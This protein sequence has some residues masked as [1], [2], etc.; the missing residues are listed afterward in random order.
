MWNQD[1]AVHPFQLV[2]C[3]CVCWT[4]PGR[5]TATTN[6][7]KPDGACGVRAKTPEFCLP[8]HI[9]LL[10][11]GSVW[12]IAW[13]M[14]KV[15]TTNVRE[16]RCCRFLCRCKKKCTPL[17]VFWVV[18]LR[19]ARGGQLGVLP[20]CCGDAHLVRVSCRGIVCDN[21]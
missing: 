16:S 15:F 18:I 14:Y 7:Q 5:M 6:K 3:E 12:A 21:L 1:D 9:T 19:V 10:Q 2:L 13:T 20:L 4:S 11:L 17:T 8:I